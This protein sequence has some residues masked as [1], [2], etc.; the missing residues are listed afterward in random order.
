MEFLV[1]ASLIALFFIGSKKSSPKVTHFLAIIVF[2]GLC[3]FLASQ[4]GN[5]ARLARGERA[6]MLDPGIFA[7]NFIM[8]LGFAMA[9]YLIG[10]GAGRWRR[11][12]SDKGGKPREDR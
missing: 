2:S 1:W 10:L 3:V 7:R 4:R 9:I 5:A 6:N 8:I 11:R 12:Y